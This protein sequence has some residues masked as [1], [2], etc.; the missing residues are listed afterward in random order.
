MLDSG[1]TRYRIQSD[2]CRGTSNN[3]QSVVLGASVLDTQSTIPEAIEVEVFGVCAMM[4]PRVQTVVG[5]IRRNIAAVKGPVVYD[6]V[7]YGTN[8]SKD[9]EPSVI[10]GER[11]KSWKI[12]LSIQGGNGWRPSG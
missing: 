4:T 1:P 7:P 9:I 11:R 10:R 2:I 6:Y 3:E 8:F 5:N 12:A